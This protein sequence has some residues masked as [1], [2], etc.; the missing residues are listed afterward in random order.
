MLFLLLLIPF[1]VS[2]LNFGFLNTVLACHSNVSVVN[3]RL[4][5]T[6]FPLLLPPFLW[7]SIM[8][9]RFMLLCQDIYSFSLLV[10]EGNCFSRICL[11]CW[12][13]LF[14]KTA[15]Q[16]IPHLPDTWI[17]QSCS[18]NSSRTTSLLI[19]PS[20][21][22]VILQKPTA[23][24]VSCRLS[25]SANVM[26]L[27]VCHM[28][29]DLWFGDLLELLKRNLVLC[30][31]QSSHHDITLTDLSSY[32]N[33][34]SKASHCLFHRETP[35]IWDASR[36][37]PTTHPSA[38]LPA[39]PKKP[40]FTHHRTTTHELSHKTKLFQKRKTED[41]TCSLSICTSSLKSLRRS[42]CSFGNKIPPA[43]L[44]NLSKRTI[45]SS[46]NLTI[47]LLDWTNF[48]FLAHSSSSWAT[49]SNKFLE[50]KCTYTD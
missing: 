48:S 40:V 41:F 25:L 31:T 5:W 10:L 32:A 20:G 18:S 12:V 44:C 1:S 6:S 28:N 2:T 8:S 22:C 11:L 35:C 36:K 24:F 19:G 13:S 42:S 43:S 38:F 47:I 34:S 17:T 45:W 4:S 23:L 3:K 39:F 37:E 7:S 46:R 26:E 14:F 21:M 49:F 27:E 33:S 29:E 15:S 30:L 16:M 50:S 9:Y